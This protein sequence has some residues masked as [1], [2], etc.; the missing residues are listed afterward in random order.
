MPYADRRSRARQG[1]S[2]FVEL[3]QAELERLIMTLEE[4]ME[5]AAT[6]LRLEYAACLRDEINDLRRRASGGLVLSTAHEEA[7][8]C[9]DG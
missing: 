3:P 2:D 9:L 4:E 7:D 6:D 1:R 8:R 5:E